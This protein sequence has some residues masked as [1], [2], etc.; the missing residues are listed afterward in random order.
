M[1]QTDTKILKQ[2]DSEKNELEHKMNKS[3]KET[4]EIKNKLK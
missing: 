4:N 3:I 1:I 2:L